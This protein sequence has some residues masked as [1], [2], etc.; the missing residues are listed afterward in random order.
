MIGVL[1][2]VLFQVRK[3]DRIIGRFFLWIMNFSHSGLTDWGLGHVKINKNFT[4]L[5]VGCGGGRTIQKM[6]AIATDGKIYGVDYASGSVAASRA[7]NSKLIEEGRVEITNGSV[8][9]LPFPDD[10]FDLV[11]AVETQYYWPDLV[12][13]MREILR[14]LKPGGTLIIIAESYKSGKYDKLQGPVMK[15]L[16]SSSLGLKEHRALFSKAGFAD[17][18][19]FEEPKKGW[20]CGTGKKPNLPS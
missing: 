1:L 11:T 9:Q 12:N 10:K 6:A 20:F 14:V 17:I 7:K 18:Q 3:P 4:I 13:D 15:L 8:S 2:Y 19:V 5:D 16:K